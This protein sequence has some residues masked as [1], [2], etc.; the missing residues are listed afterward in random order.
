MIILIFKLYL[1]LKLYLDSLNYFINFPKYMSRFWII[2]IGSNINIDFSVI[3]FFWH[4]C[5]YK[6][7]FIFDLVYFMRLFYNNAY[8]TMKKIPFGFVMY[9][10][11]TSIVFYS[12]LFLI[13]LLVANLIEYKWIGFSRINTHISLCAYKSTTNNRYHQ[14]SL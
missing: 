3:Y 8:S 7:T 2:F 1:Q 12:L 6:N 11:Y 5:L 13:F 14:C 4:V 10:S 9:N